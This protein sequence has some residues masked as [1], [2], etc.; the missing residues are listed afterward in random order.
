MIYPVKGMAGS[1]VAEVEMGKAGPANDRRY[2]LVD[3]VGSFVSQRTHASLALCRVDIDHH[4][5]LISTRGT[6]IKVGLDERIGHSYLAKVWDDDALVMDV[7]AKVNEWLGKHVGTG[8][9][10]VTMVDDTARSHKISGGP[11]TTYVS[12]ADGY[13]AL[14]TGT[15]S[16]DLLNSKLDQAI[17]MDRFR[18]NI[19]VKT[20]QPHVEDQWMQMRIGTAVLRHVKPCVRCQVITIDQQ[21]GQASKEP[22]KTLATYRRVDN[23]VIFGSNLIVEQPGRLKVGD[24]IEVLDGSVDVGS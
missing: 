7:S 8:L 9:R 19:V 15:A 20:E 18:A 12:L 4:H 5:M 6:S 23:G 16:L 24:T 11:A 1:S 21:T 22:L 2:M 3:A 13:P 10:L 14:I 17:K